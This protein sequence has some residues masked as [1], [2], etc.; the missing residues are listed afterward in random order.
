MFA[1]VAWQMRTDHLLRFAAAPAPRAA[2]EQASTSLHAATAE[3]RSDNSPGAAQGVSSSTVAVPAP[4]GG[5]R[6]GRKEP[7]RQSR[8]G[9]PAHPP[10]PRRTACR[11]AARL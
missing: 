9:M 7:E 11:D 2:E 4:A 3:V 6:V 10:I 5:R 8:I 1:L